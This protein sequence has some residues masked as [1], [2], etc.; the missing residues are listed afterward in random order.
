VID[1]LRIPI[2][3]EARLGLERAALHNHAVLRGVGIPR[4]DGG[5]VLLVPGFLAGDVSLGPMAGWLARI[6]HKP[7]RAGIRANVDCTA[8]ALER[9]EDLLDLLF[10]GYER[11]VTIVGQSRGGSMARI[12]A[13]RRPDVVGGIVCLGSP[14]ASQLAVHPFVRAQVAAVALLGSL[15]VPGLFSRGCLSGSCCTQVRAEAA[16]PFPEGVRFTS[17]YSRSDGIVDWHS[18]LDSGARLVEVRSSHIGMAVNPDVFRVVAEAL[19]PSSAGEGA[20]VGE[21]ER[22]AEGGVAGGE[23]WA[24][25]P[26]AMVA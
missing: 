12:L 4:G 18:C 26:D 9:V 16:A 20:G 7:C 21:G 24:G 3:G 15:G 14:L 13:V 8:R 11:P 2:W 19:A 25:A 10:E 23:G 17:V 5:P 1:Q 22:G 6:G